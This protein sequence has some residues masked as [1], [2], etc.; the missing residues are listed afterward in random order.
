MS[1]VFPD[2]TEWWKHTHQAPSSA[3]KM[4]DAWKQ[5]HRQH[6]LKALRG[7]PE[8][9]NSVYELGCG[10]GPNLRL[11][12]HEWT[13]PL[14][15]GGYEP[16]E[17]LRA[18]ASEHTGVHIDEEVPE[19]GQWDVVLSCFALAYAQPP[20]LIAT[21]AAMRKMAKRLVLLEPSAHVDPYKDWGMYSISGAL[22]AWAHDYPEA[23]KR[24]GWMAEDAWP[25]VPAVDG[26]NMCM[27]A[28]GQ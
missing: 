6:I 12:K 11:L 16:V 15:L 21:L 7:I 8:A 19:V 25:V 24:S 22:P 2:L 4:W 5:P 3:Q 18:W 20:T 28:R 23:F 27:I 13:Q 17:G 26:L 1:E 9:V 14:K 10:S